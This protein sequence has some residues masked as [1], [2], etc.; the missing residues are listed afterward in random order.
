[1]NSLVLKNKNQVFILKIVL[2]VVS[3]VP[4]FLD[5]INLP[6]KINNNSGELFIY[7]TKLYIIPIALFICTLLAEKKSLFILTL[8]TLN[9]V[10]FSNCLGFSSLYTCIGFAIDGYFFDIFVGQL[11]P[12]LHN[13]INTSSVMQVIWLIMIIVIFTMSIVILVKYSKNNYNKVPS[14]LLISFITL[15]L[16]CEFITYFYTHILLPTYYILYTIIGIYLAFYPKKFKK[17]N[18]YRLSQDISLTELNDLYII[19]KISEEQ[20]YSERQRIIDNI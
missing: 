7:L 3:L 15:C 12:F 17:H 10:Y 1:M 6:E 5:L 18:S 20:Y 13:G 8:L 19:G 16:L 2:I 14:K 9:I 11:I 4:I